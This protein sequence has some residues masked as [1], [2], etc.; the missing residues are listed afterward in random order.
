MWARTPWVL[1]LDHAKVTPFT[2]T[3]VDHTIRWS[4][5][6]LGRLPFR[7]QPIGYSTTGSHH[8][9]SWALPHAGEG[10]EDFKD[11]KEGEEVVN[12]ERLKPHQGRTSDA[13]M[14]FLNYYFIIWNLMNWP[15][16]IK[17]KMAKML[18]SSSAGTS[19]FERFPL[20]DTLTKTAG[21][22]TLY[23]IYMYIKT[24]PHLK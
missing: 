19:F 15:I 24:L 13:G 20:R 22:I 12:Q 5:R 2:L 8:V 7:F 3:V 10:T 14:H 11:K 18:N 21:N 1:C 9:P 6:P 17:N 23:S 4:T 16:F